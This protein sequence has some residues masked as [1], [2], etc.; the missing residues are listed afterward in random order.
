MKKIIKIKFICLLVLVRCS[1]SLLSYATEDQIEENVEEQIKYIE[2]IT[3]E[4]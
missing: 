1:I 4:N 3:K 2:S